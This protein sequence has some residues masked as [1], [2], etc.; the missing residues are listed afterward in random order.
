[1]RR[2]YPNSNLRLL[3]RESITALETNFEII[4]I[5]NTNKENLFLV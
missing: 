2:T 3:T 5:E 4:Q 1:M